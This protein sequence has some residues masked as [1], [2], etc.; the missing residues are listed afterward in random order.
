MIVGPALD[1][2]DK[3]FISLGRRHEE[4]VYACAAGSGARRRINWL[5]T[6]S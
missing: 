1:E 6:K 3:D 5:Q 4:K 2:L